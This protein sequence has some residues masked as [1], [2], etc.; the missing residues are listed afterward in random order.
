V[1]GMWHVNGCSMPSET[2][3]GFADD[4]DLM[5][6]RGNYMTRE[7]GGDTQ[8]I[9]HRRLGVVVDQENERSNIK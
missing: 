6:P 2:P 9:N 3:G 5:I 8:L 4:Y 1:S 7:R